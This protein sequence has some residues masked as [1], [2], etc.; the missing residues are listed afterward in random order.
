MFCK[1]EGGILGSREYWGGSWE[2][3]IVTGLMMDSGK[4]EMI[5]YALTLVDC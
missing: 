1:D 5:I 3:G 2:Q 4:E